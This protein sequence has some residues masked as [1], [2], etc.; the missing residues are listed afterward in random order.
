MAI[1]I[2]LLFVECKA[3]TNNTTEYVI[4]SYNIRYDNNCDRQ[5]GYSWKERSEQIAKLIKTDQF[6]VFGVQEPFKHQIN[7]M[8]VLLID[9]Q[10][11]GVS[12]DN[13]P[14]SKSNHHHDIFYKKDKFNLQAQGSFWLSTGGPDTP[15]EDLMKAAYG[16]KAKVCT[17]GKFEDKQVGTVF[18]VFNTHYYYANETT[19][20]NSA[21]LTLQK[22]KE[23]AGTFP[24]IFM[25]DLNITP[26]S[27][28]YQ[29]LNSTALLSDSYYMTQSKIPEDSLQYNTFNSWKPATNDTLNHY[30]RIDYI[31]L[32]NHW[33]DKVKSNTVIWDTY[34]KEGIQKMP[35]DH[36]PVMVKL[37]MPE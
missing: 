26:D 20:N 8:E 19:K 29:T 15:P 3:D 28:A 22:V 6:D 11:F 32:S 30:K 31:F 5:K 12:D 7:D 9:Y 21:T 33:E 13:Q 25:G 14:D 24:V 4:A 2:S 23:I 16:G 10:R 27:K 36:N 37:L 17:W 35:S 34:E 1:S 18:Y